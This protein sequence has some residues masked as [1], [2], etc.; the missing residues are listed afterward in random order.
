ML[1]KRYEKAHIQNEW[2]VRDGYGH[3]V[4]GPEPFSEETATIAVTAL[5]QHVTANDGV[6]PQAN[7]AWYVIAKALEAH[8]A[9]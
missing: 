7:A 1:F 5:N 9:R 2:V 8:R 3:R 6:M 4:E